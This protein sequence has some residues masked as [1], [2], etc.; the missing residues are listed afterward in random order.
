LS[1]N[2]FDVSIFGFPGGTEI[3]NPVLLYITGDFG[4]EFQ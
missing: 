4:K 1:V 2:G 3:E